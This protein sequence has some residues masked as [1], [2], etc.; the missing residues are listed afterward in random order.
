MSQMT[1]WQFVNCLLLVSVLGCEGA[2]PGPPTFPV[3]GKVLVDGKPA[4]RAQVTFQAIE[5]P[6]ADE[7]QV[8]PFAVV[9]PDGSFRAADG[10]PAGTYNVMI[11]W[12]EFRI[13]LGEEIAGPDRLRD[14]QARFKATINEGPN[15][16]P[17]FEIKTR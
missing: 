11:V 16:L 14:V 5:P 7:R 17:T 15:E 4:D 8:L 10:A 9:E 1:R 13:E 2:S 6:T 12:P 3:S